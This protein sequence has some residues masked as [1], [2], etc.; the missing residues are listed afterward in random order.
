MVNIS[1]ICRKVS[2][3]MS[4]RSY[5][6]DWSSILGV[7]DEFYLM[8]VLFHQNPSEFFIQEN[9]DSVNGTLPI[10][11]LL[12]TTLPSR[13]ALRVCPA[14][15]RW[16]EFMGQGVASKRAYSYWQLLHSVTK[17]TWLHFVLCAI[18]F[19]NRF[20]CGLTGYIHQ[21]YHH[22]SYYQSYVEKIITSD[23]KILFF[24]IFFIYIEANTRSTLKRR[25]NECSGPKGG[26]Y[27]Q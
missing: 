22:L 3:N 6:L 1:S 21:N 24:V 12:T 2:L 9:F 25:Q 13:T 23:W 16:H 17:N 14:W 8:G 10:L 7:L 5:C 19:N 15:I 26:Y 4:I 20:W 18:I 11:D 27:T